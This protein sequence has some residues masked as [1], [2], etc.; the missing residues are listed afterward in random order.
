MAK[1]ALA[2]IR[3]EQTPVEINSK[4]FVGLPGIVLAF[5]HRLHPLFK[6]GIFAMRQDVVS[7]F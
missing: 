5:I 2:A 3:G 6:D 7:S 1:V 4:V